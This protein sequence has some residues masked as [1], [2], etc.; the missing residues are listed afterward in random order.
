MNA[1]DMTAKSPRGM[2]PMGIFLLFAA[3]M[4][5]LAGTTL[6]W[7]GSPLDRMWVLNPR[8][9]KVLAPLGR[10][11]GFLFLVLSA[12]LAASAAGWFRRRL[13]GWRLAV[14]IMLVHV[15]GD[16]ANLLLGRVMEGALGV[17]IAGA[18]LFYLS[19]ANVRAAFALGSQVKRPANGAG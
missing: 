11:V 1:S 5:C 19:R 3:V 2:T 12:A 4:A 17:T 8:I 13:W 10:A 15:S 16:M 7:P 9:Y 18:L 6:V 14:G